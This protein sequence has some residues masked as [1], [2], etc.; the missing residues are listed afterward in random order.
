M[1]AVGEHATDGCCQGVSIAGTEEGAGLAIADQFPV[2]ANVGSN[3]KLALG[4]GFERL[5]GWHQIGH[6]HRFSRIAQQVDLAVI[7]LDF[8]VRHAPGKDDAIV[9]PE[10]FRLLTQGLVLRAAT[11]QQ[12]FELRCFGN[13]CLLAS[14]SRSSPS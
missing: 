3:Q 14:S 9:E 7:A 1:L 12:D 4:H 11:N 10:S 8:A 13:N 5:E 6:P 2:T